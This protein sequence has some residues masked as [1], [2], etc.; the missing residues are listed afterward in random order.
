[1]GFIRFLGKK[2]LEEWLFF[3]SLIGF[4]ATSLYLK[5]FPHYT[6][7][8]F[9]VLFTLFV[10][11]LLTKA[12][13]E[14]NFLKLLALKV[15]KGSFVELKLVLFTFFLSM[16]ITNDVALFVVVPLTLAM[17]LPNKDWLVVLEAMAANGGSAV[18]PIGNPQNIFIYYHYHLQPLEFVKAI[19]PLGIVSLILLVVSTFLIFGSSKG[20]IKKPT[21]VKVS[22]EAYP[23]LVFFAIFTSA[24]LKLLPLWVG[25]IPILYAVIFNRKYFL[26]VDY[27]LLLTFFLFFGITDNLTLLWNFHFQNPS[28]VFLLS[29]LTSLVI[30][31]VPAAL[32]FAKFT[33]HW[34]A[35]L[36]GVNVGGFGSLIGS[37]ANLIAYRF[38][39]QKYG[40]GKWL[41]FLFH[42]VGLGFLM[43]G[44]GGFLMK[45]D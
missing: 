16:F 27:F 7:E 30:S 24:V 28:E 23:Y 29:T 15:E 22:K 33:H 10:F 12:L 32:L 1:M 34:E 45:L 26:K 19:Y 37:M 6:E 40:K 20:R 31:N 41:F 25:V 8:D 38:Y 13:E 5:R 44:V 21:S 11:L 39:V 4:L 17:N 36:W 35:L 43:V 2:L 14:G 9:K 3:V 42:L 18:S